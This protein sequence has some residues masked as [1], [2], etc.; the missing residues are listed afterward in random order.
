MEGGRAPRLNSAE[1]ALLE[2]APACMLG[3]VAEIGAEEAVSDWC[4]IWRHGNEHMKAAT[5]NLM[6]GNLALLAG[7]EGETRS[8]RS[9][10]QPPHISHT[11]LT[12][13]SRSQPEA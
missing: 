10:V 7:I 11:T 12:L 8:M 5:T 9:Q 2:V 3:E 6:G 1:E 4:G 13:H